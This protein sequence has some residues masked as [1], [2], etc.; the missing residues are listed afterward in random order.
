MRTRPKAIICLML[1][2]FSSCSMERSVLTVENADD[3]LEL[4]EFFISGERLKLYACLDEYNRADGMRPET[5]SATGDEISYCLEDLLDYGAMKT[6]TFHGVPYSQ[7]PFRQDLEPVFASIHKNVDFNADSC[8]VVRKYLIESQWS[9]GSRAHCIVV[10]IPETGFKDSERYD[11]LNKGNFSGLCLFTSL[12]GRMVCFERYLSGML[13]PAEPLLPDASEEVMEYLSLVEMAKAKSDG[14][15][16]PINGSVCIGYKWL[17]P[18]YCNGDLNGGGSGDNG[19]S[20]GTG[21]CSG[22]GFRRDTKG[23]AGEPLLP[24]DELYT[25]NVVSNAAA[26]SFPCHGRSFAKG[27]TVFVSPDLKIPYDPDKYVFSSWVGD[28]SAEKKE[29]FGLTVEDDYRSIAY[30]NLPV[31]CIDIL[32]GKG[33]PLAVM[34]ITPAGGWNY[35]GGT[36]GNTRNGGKR[37]HQGIDFC[38]Q[39]GTPVFSM[40]DGVVTMVI[41]TYE[42]KHVPGKYGNEIYIESVFEEKTIRVQYAHLQAGTPIADNPFSGSKLKVG[43]FVFQGQLIGYTGRTGNAYDD[44]DVPN[45]HLHLGVES[46]EGRWIDPAPY[47]NGDIDA[48]HTMANK[49]RIDNIKCD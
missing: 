18:S 15:G 12:D 10:M 42:D 16:I 29:S 27:S 48:K 26:V 35:Y 34:S 33:N 14:D 9:D 11:F 31:P 37:S 40:L 6:E 28:F 41:D 4:S 25:L 30:Y 20:S 3:H 23:D 22:S 43:D 13:Q 2:M 49:G 17:D 46:M 19:N 8:S 36:F 1:M 7:I 38:A 5:K 32:T 39:P 24:N 21:G 44:K 47:V 45:K